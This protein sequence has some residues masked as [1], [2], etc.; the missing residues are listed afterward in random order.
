MVLFMD[1]IDN[2]IKSVKIAYLKTGGEGWPAR[3]K[4]LT[5]SYI[6]LAALNQLSLLNK[7]REKFSDKQISNLFWSTTQIRYLITGEFVVG[8]KILERDFKKPNTLEII[9]ATKYLLHL[10]ELK[11]SEDPF[12]LNK[13]NTLTQKEVD[14]IVSSKNLNSKNLQEAKILSTSLASL[15]WAYGY[16]THFSN[17]M[18]IQ[19]PYAVKDSQQLIIREFNFKEIQSVWKDSL[20][21]PERVKILLLYNNTDISNDWELHLETKSEF[22]L[23]KAK[24]VFVEK[25]KEKNPSINEINELIQK[26]N[27]ATIQQVSYVNSLSVI[28]KVKKGAM[29]SFLQTK[30]LSDL[31]NLDWKPTKEINEIITAKAEDV[32]FEKPKSTKAPYLQ[33]PDWS[34]TF[35]PRIPKE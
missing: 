1:S 24:I 3:G 20:V 21:L 4:R 32:W 7:V 12:C 34:T 6:H 25:G 17:F 30:N 18:E 11:T 13:N 10:L 15:S 19:G 8:L 16:D 22:N 33:A 9:S 5:S 29:L 23:V 35:D 14:S 31:L 28:D 26:S 27:A 2:Y